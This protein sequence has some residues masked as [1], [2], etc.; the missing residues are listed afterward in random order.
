[1]W[2]SSPLQ[3]ALSEEQL[4]DSV[5]QLHYAYY[6][7]SLDDLVTLTE[8]LE[9]ERPREATEQWQHYYAALG[10][11]RAALLADDDYVTEYLDRCEDLAKQLLRKQANFVEALVLRGA[12]AA[13][14][15]EKRPISAVLAPSRAVRSFAKARAIDPEHPRLLLQQAKAAMGRRAFVDEFPAADIM[16]QQSLDSFLSRQD[17]DALT[18]DWGEVE[19]HTELARLLLEK[20]E[21]RRARDS[22]E[23]ALQFAPGYEPALALLETLRQG[24]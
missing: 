9:N 6:T 19:A 7:R 24:G 5:A 11:Y 13:F 21:R 4:V 23:Q 1:M 8:R 18:P 14:L 17:A 22:I 16:L 12:C 10:Y 15:A 2:L 3:A 20:G